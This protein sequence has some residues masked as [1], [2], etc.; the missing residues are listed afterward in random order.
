LV[1]QKL[2]EFDVPPREIEVYSKA[3]QTH[4]TA[5]FPDESINI[6]TGKSPRDVIH[7]ESSLV[8]KKHEE[9]AAVTTAE[10]EPQPPPDLPPEEKEKIMQTP[11]FAEFITKSSKIIERALN[12][13]SLYD[14][15]VDYSAADEDGKLK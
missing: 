13:S 8:H 14:I 1:I 3:T 7:A 2:Q 12:T 9:A 15:T 4:S 6:S 11:A 10:K 5:E